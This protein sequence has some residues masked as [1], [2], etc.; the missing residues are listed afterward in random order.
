M[1]ITPPTPTNDR[2]TAA[3][4]R[5]AFQSLTERLDQIEASLVTLRDGLTAAAQQPAPAAAPMGAGQV[6]TFD[7]SII[8]VGIDDN[9]QYTY[10]AKGGQYLKFGVRIWPE[11]LPALG[12][13]P[14]ELKPGPNPCSLRLVALMGERGPRKVISLGK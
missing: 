4:L 13:D 5:D 12:I 6:V 7:A 8:L 10:K 9:G 2:I 11:V 3:E 1:T 14:D